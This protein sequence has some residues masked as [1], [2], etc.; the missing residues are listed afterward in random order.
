MTS[1]DISSCAAGFFC[2][3][4][5]KVATPY[6]A[7]DSINGLTKAGPCPAGHYCPQ[8][9]QAGTACPKGTY[10]PYTG[11]RSESDCMPVPPG[12]FSTQTGLTALPSSSSS[13]YGDCTA[14]YYC[15]GGSYEPAPSV[16]TIGVPCSIG[17]YCPAGTTRQI[18]CDP[19]WYQDTT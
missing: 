6:E 17:H 13:T 3:E 14:G 9:S 5:A 7:G 18:E 11:G 12:K 19:G 15:S 16:S 10:R 8:G 1:S 2:E 4:G